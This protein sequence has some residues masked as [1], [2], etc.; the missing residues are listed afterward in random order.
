[1]CSS[2]LVVYP[3]PSNHHRPLPHAAG[4][5]HARL[6]D[7]PGEDTFAGLRGYRPGDSPRHIAWKAVARGLALQTKQFAGA[8]TGVIWLDW[9]DAEGDDPE[10]RLSRLARWALQ[11]DASGAD[12]GMRL[13]E[14]EFAAARG[15]GHLHRCL[16]ALALHE[17]HVLEP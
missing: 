1:V 14:G 12:W 8:P 13:P 11:A 7:T 10:A 5:G 16:H 3:R 6:T 2:D 9:R 4:S 15:S 17:P